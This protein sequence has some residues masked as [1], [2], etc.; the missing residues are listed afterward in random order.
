[1]TL[2]AA[3]PTIPTDLR[4]I[5]L[6]TEHVRRYG[7]ARLTVTEIAETA[8]MSHANIYRYFSSKA[9]LIEAVSVAWLAP[10]EASLRII[11]DA[12]DPAYDKLERLIFAVH[13]AYREKAV[14]DPRL[15]ELF[16]AAAIAQTDVVRK[17]QQ[18]IARAI[19]RVLDEG[20]S[21]GA[22]T[23]NN[24]ESAVNLV[25]DA[26]Y[27]FLSPVAVRA[28][29]GSTPVELETRGAQMLRVIS[30]AFANRDFED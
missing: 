14:R 15:F 7:P 20:G 19:H 12:P 3:G 18:R 24:Q 5:E 8:G 16:C 2:R 9:A 26:M 23:I 25:L 10:I 22:Y 29:L 13:R 21:S 28:D 1:M 4:I 27:R 30:Q 11:G 6:A 17:H